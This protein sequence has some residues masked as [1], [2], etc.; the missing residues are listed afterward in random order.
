MLKESATGEIVILRKI[1]NRHTSGQLEQLASGAIMH[2]KM[3]RSFKVV[4]K[5]N[6]EE[7]QKM[8]RSH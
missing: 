3:K 6:V 7:I 4:L 2:D 8:G 5:D 1:Q